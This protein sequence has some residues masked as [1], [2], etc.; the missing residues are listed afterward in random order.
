[1]QQKQRADRRCDDP[2]DYVDWIAMRSRGLEHHLTRLATRF[3]LPTGLVL[4][5][6]ASLGRI[7]NGSVAPATLALE[8]WFL[9]SGAVVL[10]V[11]AGRAEWRYLERTFDGR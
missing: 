3:G 8:W 2:E 6:L 11:I 9:T 4:S 10:T 5:L 7:G 1:M